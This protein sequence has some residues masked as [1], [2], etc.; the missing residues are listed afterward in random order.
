CFLLIL[1]WLIFPLPV[2]FGR[3]FALNLTFGAR[4]LPALGLANIGIVA[5]SMAG[6]IRNLG[7]RRLLPVT[8][9]DLMYFS[10][11][12]LVCAALFSAANW[13]IAQFFSV[14]EILFAAV[15]AAGLFVL[16]LTRRQTGFA[17]TLLVPQLLIFGPV[18]PVERGLPV[19][20]QSELR[21]F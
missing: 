13:H 1:S 20:V 17:V 9:R 19:F 10:A 2:A 4:C 15:L 21:R 3:I 11:A 7:T 16:M 14:A 12:L 6:L 8:K 5:I 18:N